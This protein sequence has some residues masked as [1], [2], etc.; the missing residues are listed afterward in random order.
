MY[1]IYFGMCKCIGVCVI[2]I[3]VCYICMVFLGV[4]NNNMYDLFII[5]FDGCAK[6]FY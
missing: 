3:F 4:L 1:D 2:Y 5:V 6:Y